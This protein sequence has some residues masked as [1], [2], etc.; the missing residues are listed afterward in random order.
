MIDEIHHHRKT[1]L[2]AID[3]MIST[4]SDGIPILNHFNY[5]LI[6]SAGAYEAAKQNIN[7][8]G[9]GIVLETF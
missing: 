5:N 8:I 2:K 4:G 9:A 7:I 1:S 3:C 6:D